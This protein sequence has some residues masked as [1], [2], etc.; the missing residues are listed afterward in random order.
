[1]EFLFAM[2]LLSLAGIVFSWISYVLFKKN[3]IFSPK[4]LVRDAEVVDNVASRMASGGTSYTPVLFYKIGEDSYKEQ[5][6]VGYGK[7]VKLG[8]RIKIKVD[9]ANPAKPHMN[10][11]SNYIFPSMFLAGALLIWGTVVAAVIRKFFLS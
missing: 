2:I 9:P 11:A 1:M 8:T 10:V 7:A 6:D 3:V 4:A 5:G